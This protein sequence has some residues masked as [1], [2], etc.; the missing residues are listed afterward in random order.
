M[1]V[2][3]LVKHFSSPIEMQAAVD[4]GR[5][6]GCVLI[7]LPSKAIWLRIGPLDRILRAPAPSILHRKEVILTPHAGIVTTKNLSS[8]TTSHHNYRVYLKVV[9]HARNVG[10]HHASI[11][12]TDV[13]NLLLA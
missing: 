2:D 11:G 5:L 3:I 9:A 4:C 13:A 1:K 8:A 12:E 10:L 6:V 7:L